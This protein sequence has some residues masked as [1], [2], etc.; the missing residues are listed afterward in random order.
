MSF[1]LSNGAF[2][3]EELGNILNDVHNATDADF[4]QALN[5]YLSGDTNV[6]F[7]SDDDTFKE[8]LEKNYNDLSLDAQTK[9]LLGE[10]EFSD[11]KRQFK[12]KLL[13][14][15]QESA[16]ESNQDPEEPNELLTNYIAERYKEIYADKEAPKIFI[17]GSE[18]D[19][20]TIDRKGNLVGK[21]G[22]V[23]DLTSE[24]PL[25][26]KPDLRIDSRIKEIRYD[27]STGAF[28]A[29][30]SRDG[31][32]NNY[33]ELTWDTGQMTRDSTY[34]VSYTHLT[35]PTK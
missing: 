27:S 22:A 24:A 32:S 2:T 12:T 11:Y 25:E 21:H 7:D 9:I 10:K 13:H 15:Y 31:A 29:S 34:A 30:Y 8:A 6:R 4:V 35:L 33:L 1:V 17:S 14:M 23:I 18:S 5:Q 3:E 28:T 16:L 19:S 26:E 20:L